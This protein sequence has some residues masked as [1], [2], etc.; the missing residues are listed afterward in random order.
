MPQKQK[1]SYKFTMQSPKVAQGDEPDQAEL[2][3]D[4]FALLGI[5]K[6]DRA[7]TE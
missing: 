5:K 7:E 2:Q 3:A 6:E 1:Y 4:V